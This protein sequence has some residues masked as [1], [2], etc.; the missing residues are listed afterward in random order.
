MTK[1]YVLGLECVLA[2]GGVINTGGKMRKN[3]AGYD[4]TALFVGSEGTLGIITKA[5]LRL[6]PLPETKKQAFLLLNKPLILRRA[7]PI[8]SV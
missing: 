4:L 2:T 1:D 6:L 7:F 3:V 8:F 5:L